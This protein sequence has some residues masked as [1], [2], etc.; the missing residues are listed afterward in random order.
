MLWIL[1]ALL[2]PSAHAEENPWWLV[3]VGREHTL[4]SQADNG[5]FLCLHARPAAAKA[6]KAKLRPAR[7]E[8]P[9]LSAI[10]ELGPT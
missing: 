10:P 1:V 8:A 4:C 7:A 2:G 5:Q 6:K 3:A 9:D